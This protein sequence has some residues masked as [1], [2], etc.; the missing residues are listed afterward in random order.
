[1]LMNMFDTERN[2]TIG[3]NEFSR[4]WQYIADWQRVFKHF[5][6]DHSGTIERRELADALRN[7]GYTLSPA[8]L[9][10]LERKYASGATTAAYGPIPGIT[11]DRF[12]RACVAIKT[13]T[14]AFQRVDTDNDGWARF[15]YEEFMRVITTAVWYWM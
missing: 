12:V 13:L 8:L 1:M 6:R 3:F 14:E 15:S 2:G 7:F 10:L 5:D 4:L 11:F 9:S